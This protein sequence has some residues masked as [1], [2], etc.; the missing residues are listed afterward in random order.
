VTAAGRPYLATLA[1]LGLNA[2]LAA[3]FV[4]IGAALFADPAELFRELMPGTWLSF[5]ELLLIA[6]TAWAIHRRL[7]PP[8]RRRRL[9]SFWGASAIIFV[10]FAVDEI[11]QATIFLADGLTRAGALA[12]APFKDLDSFLITAVFLASGAVLLRYLRDLLRYPAALG[13]LIVGGALGVG[14]QALDSLFASTS[15]EFVAEESLKLAAEPFLL[16]AYLVVL[17]RVIRQRGGEAQP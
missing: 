4:P 8:A 14:M 13:L 12:P 2:T 9:D 1:L 16:G 10:V 7:E 6:A 15:D 3:A 11:T 5:A 17:D